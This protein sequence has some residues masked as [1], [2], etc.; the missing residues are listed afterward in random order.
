VVLTLA[1]VAGWLGVTGLFLAIASPSMNFTPAV[2]TLLV[3]QLVVTPGLAG[4]LATAWR[5][6]EIDRLQT[7]G[8]PGAT[9]ISANWLFFVALW[10]YEIVNFPGQDLPPLKW[11]STCRFCPGSS[12]QFLA[13]LTTGCGARSTRP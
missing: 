6:S 5:A 3:C 7:I 12:V 11:T 9:G 1:F 13:S 2:G 8:L 10:L 4:V